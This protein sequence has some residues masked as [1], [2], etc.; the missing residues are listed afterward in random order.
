MNKIRSDNIQV[1]DREEEKRQILKG[2]IPKLRGF[3]QIQ[4]PLNVVV[5]PDFFV[6]RIIEVESDAIFFKDIKR[7]INAGGG[8]MRGYHSKDIKGG[9]AVNVAYSLASLGIKVKLYT[10]SDSVGSFILNAVF[11]LFGEDVELH[12]VKGKHGLSSV[13]EFIVSSDKARDLPESLF[14]LVL[15]SSSV[16]VNN[17]PFSEVPSSISNVMVSDVGD[18]DNF[19]PELIDTQ[20][21]LNN[22]KNAHAVIFTN[23]ASNFRGT[24]LMKYVFSNSP[25]SIHFA[26]PADFELR[27]FELV[28]TFKNNSRL[29][30]VLSINENE[31][32]HIVRTL[33]TVI[34]NTDRK[35]LHYFDGN[36]CPENVYNLSTSAEFIHNYLGLR[37]CIH[38]TKGS[39]LADNNGVVFVGSFTPSSMNIISGAGDSWDAGFMFGELLRFEKEEK[40]AFAN[41]LAMLHI[42]NSEGDDPTLHKVI[43]YIEKM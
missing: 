28:N 19:G 1:Y 16:S 42:E 40:L 5:L 10:V 34:S 15:S 3:D 27:S 26:D 17:T 43:G 22:L 29:I 33:M 30:D 8:S 36:E 4:T 14:Q 32:N 13:F 6:D 35:S 12:I 11:S 20:E 41:L 21:M 37:V 9:N 23:W 7:K 25:H 24:D 38:T 39:I 31:Y 18:N 2:I